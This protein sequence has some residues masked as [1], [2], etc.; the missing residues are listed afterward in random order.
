MKRV[1]SV[2]LISLLILSL[3]AC[4]NNQTVDTNSTTGGTTGSAEP[5]P[6][7]TTG[8][9]GQ[10]STSGAEQSTT[11]VGGTQATTA[12]V[13]GTQ[14]TTTVSSTDKT[15]KP[16]G[17]GNVVQT[18]TR[19]KLDFPSSSLG[20]DKKTVGDNI[21]SP[22]SGVKYTLKWMD[23]FNGTTLD[24]K[25]WTVRTVN[26]NA[27]EGQVNKPENV[28]VANGKLSFEL[29][30]ETATCDGGNG[31]TYTKK[32]TGG[33]IDSQGKQYFK[34]GRIEVYCKLPYG[35]GMWP[36]FWTVGDTTVGDREAWWP[37]GGEIDIMEMFGKSNTET[38]VSGGVW[39]YPP[40]D[41]ENFDYSKGKSKSR[42]GD[43]SIRHPKSK[44]SDGYHLY[45]IE[46]T[47]D[48]LT[49]YFDN[50]NWGTIDISGYDFSYAMH[51]YHMLI[52]NYAVEGFGLIPGTN[53]QRRYDGREPGADAV[54][55][56]TFDVDWVK[57][58]QR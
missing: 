48:T 14:A 18:T 36:A 22:L 10:Q 33:K 26:A 25:N 2:L 58:W 3:A 42:S 23:D 56:Q 28:K 9:Q 40:Q 50:E 35:K 24:S 7:E 1:I 34:Y 51:N 49:F 5:L 15:T 37:W 53:G 38:V 8:A 4:G 12:A 52:L 45:G 19:K 20:L 32:F 43:A 11:A 54:I 27:S 57:V 21:L 55:P 41:Y 44:F 30:R 17:S 29:K 16:A 39:Y 47:R 6:S 46:W 13:S 31:L